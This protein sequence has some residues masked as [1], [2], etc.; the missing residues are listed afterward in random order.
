MENTTSGI[1]YEDIS[2]AIQLASSGDVLTLSAL[3]FTERLLIQ[4]PLTIVG[5]AGGGTVIDVRGTSG[6]GVW[7]GSS[8]I[9]ME[10]VTIL[11]DI[12]HDGYG[13][14]CDPGTTDLTL[15]NVRVLN[16]G[17]SGIDLNGLVGPGI[18]LIEDCEVL[19]AASGFGL[20]LSSC[21]S[22]VVRNFTSSG[23]GFGDIGILESAYTSNRTGS[24]K[25]EGT[26]ALSGPQS[27]GLA[28][29]VVSHLLSLSPCRVAS[30]LTLTLSC[31]ILASIS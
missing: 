27:N 30:P 7:L 13:V 25:F 10:N 15:R 11:S 23:N 28:H 22:T 17:T 19:D 9:T 20:A 21:Q 29:P 8:G 5:D 1:G 31:R 18:N 14:H 4:K 3:T 16:N 24:L 26:M 2:D 6:W 12:S